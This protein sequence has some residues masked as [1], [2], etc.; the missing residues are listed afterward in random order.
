MQIF[1]K[2]STELLTIIIEESDSIAVLKQK[3]E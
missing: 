3:I 2:T 1:V